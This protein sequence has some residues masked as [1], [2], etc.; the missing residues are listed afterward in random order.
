MN[1]GLPVTLDMRFFESPTNIFSSS[2]PI[3]ESKITVLNS[4]RNSYAVSADIGSGSVSRNT[5]V[6]RFRTRFSRI[7]SNEDVG[8]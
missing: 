8:L 3:R 5:N 7:I 6:W 4:F 1:G 2:S